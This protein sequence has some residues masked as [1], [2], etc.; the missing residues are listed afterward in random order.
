MMSAYFHF[1][2]TLNRLFNNYIKLYW[3]NISS[4]WNMKGGKVKLTS[5]PAKI[6][7]KSPAL[8]GL[9]WKYQCFWFCWEGSFVQYKTGGSEEENKQ[10][11]LF[12]DHNRK[13]RFRVSWKLCL[14]L[15][16]CKWLRTSRNLIPY[17]MHLG[18]WKLNMLSGNGL[19]NCSKDFLKM[20]ILVKFR[21][22]TSNLFHSR[23]TETTKSET[24]FNNRLNTD[25]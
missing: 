21:I 3:Y 25:Y 17:V 15:C 12:H 4:S 22:S 14:N 23:I 5:P 24:T 8:L 9:I 1:Q 10:L 6:R 7:S 16:S 2:H 20:F 19:T 18:L 11:F 13:N